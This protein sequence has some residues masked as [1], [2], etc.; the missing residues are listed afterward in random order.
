MYKSWTL[1]F[2][3]HDD[4]HAW[5]TVL[6]C[7]APTGRSPR[8]STCV[9]RWRGVAQSWLTLATCRSAIA[10]V[11]VAIA[12]MK[13]TSYSE[14]ELCTNR[15]GVNF[16]SEFLQC[17]QLNF[18]FTSW[19]ECWN[20]IDPNTGEYL[21]FFPHPSS[22][23]DSLFPVIPSTILSTSTCWRRSLYVLTHPVEDSSGC[24]NSYFAM[25]STTQVNTRRDP[26]TP[27]LNTI[28]NYPHLTFT[29]RYIICTI[30]QSALDLSLFSVLSYC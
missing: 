14:I 17:M 7:P 25:P 10:T 9:V 12:T 1:T 4:W 3:I 29:Q 6:S 18:N 16:N 24:R 2:D 15:V 19:I 20:G 21:A 13:R 11:V 23:S 22:L 8:C 27:T 26:Q 28:S 30:T 5:L